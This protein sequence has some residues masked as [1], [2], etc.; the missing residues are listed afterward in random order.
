M[1]IAERINL[2]KCGYSRAEIEALA[3]AEKDQVIPDP[4]PED[5]AP[6]DPTPAPATDPV[7]EDPAPADPTPAPATDPVLAAI[8]E[9]TQAIYAQNINKNQQPETKESVA[10]LIKKL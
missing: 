4:V 6:A 8:K 3:A 1:T 9:L 5:P 10:D 7:P 2:H